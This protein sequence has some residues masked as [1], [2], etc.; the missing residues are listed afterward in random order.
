MG[1]RV[2]LATVAA[3]FFCATV[4]PAAEPTPDAHPSTAAVKQ[5]LTAVIDAQLAAFRANDYPKAYTFAAAGIQ[6][7]FSRNQFEEMVKTAYPVIAHS[8]KA[9]YGLAFDTGE[10]AVVNVTV[11]N[12]DGQR[13]QYQYLLK[14][15]DGAWKINGVAE[16][17]SDGMSV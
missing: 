5:E 1:R 4:V 10:E 16:L 8:A 6:G 17:K 12:A 15:E 3:V 7:M 11:E 9:E 14:K 13:T 2:L